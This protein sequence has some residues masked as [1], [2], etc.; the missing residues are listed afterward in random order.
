MA[1]YSLSL[2]STVTTSGAAS[3]DAKAAATNEPSVME[4][5]VMNGA[6]TA[7]TYGYG[8]SANTPTQTSPVLVQADD[9][10]R[11]A[12]LTGCA[13]AWSV[14]PTLP[15]QFFRRVFLPA[16]IGAGMIWTFPAGIVLGAAAASLV[17]W[18]LAA[19]SASVAVHVV[20]DE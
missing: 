20:V 15:T 6:A 1:T 13:V 8:R 12:G 4:L 11:P 3:W 5:G 17:Q 16:T 9:V 2:A 10:D 19:S 7:C 14:A 18:N